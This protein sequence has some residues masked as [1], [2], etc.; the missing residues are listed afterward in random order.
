MSSR[1][2]EENAGD[3]K[4]IYESI[5]E[6]PLVES[7]YKG[8]SILNKQDNEINED[9]VPIVDGIHAGDNNIF[10]NHKKEYSYDDVSQN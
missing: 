5:I 6:Q 7:D 9:I 1:L 2:N 4:E 8:E 3:S 10:S